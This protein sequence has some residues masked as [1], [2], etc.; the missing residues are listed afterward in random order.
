M[1]STFAKSGFNR[2]TKTEHSNQA[3][4]H[5]EKRSHLI[6]VLSE[7]SCNKKKILRILKKKYQQNRKRL[8][9]LT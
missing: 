8:N 3:N 4:D 5:P 9:R 2:Y 7:N 1:R 6:S